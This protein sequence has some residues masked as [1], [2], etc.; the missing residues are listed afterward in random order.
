MFAGDSARWR[1]GLARQNF[2]S[3]EMADG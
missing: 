3:R 2:V 1:G